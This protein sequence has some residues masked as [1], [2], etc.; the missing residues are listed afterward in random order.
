MK[1]WYFIRHFFSKPGTDVSLF[2]TNFLHGVEDP[3]V[4][5]FEIIA[6]ISANQK[7]YDPRARPPLAVVDGGLVPAADWHCSDERCEERPKLSLE[8][9]VREEDPSVARILGC[10]EL[11]RRRVELFTAVFLKIC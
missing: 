1:F 6:H 11:P 10:D 2:I 9:A 3:T 7:F 5:C 8:S 4:Q